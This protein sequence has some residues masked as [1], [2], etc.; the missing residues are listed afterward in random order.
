MQWETEVLCVLVFQIA[1]VI[2]DGEQ[3]TNDPFTELS[4]A[5]SGIKNKGVTV[6]ALGIG[7]RVKLSEL[8]SIASSN[9]SVSSASSFKELQNLTDRMRA[10]LCKGMW[11]NAR[12]HCS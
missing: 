5:S 6:Y 3:T 4:I 10:S 7:K 8:Q 1:V 12:L 9:D 11:Y 2:T